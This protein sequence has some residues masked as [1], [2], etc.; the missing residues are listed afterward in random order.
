VAQS[1]AWEKGELHT[2]CLSRISSSRDVLPLRAACISSLA[3]PR[4]AKLTLVAGG[5]V[6][7]PACCQIEE[8]VGR[9]GRPASSLRTGATKF[10]RQARGGR[11]CEPATVWL[12]GS[13]S[14]TVRRRHAAVGSRPAA[15]ARCAR[16]LG[17]SAPRACC[18]VPFECRAAEADNTQLQQVVPNFASSIVHSSIVCKQGANCIWRT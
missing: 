15:W 13:R 8:G 14:C 3:A 5:P 12:A 1:P 9:R 7:R 6:V 2:G 10:R 4:R 16:T 17:R 11:C 18:A